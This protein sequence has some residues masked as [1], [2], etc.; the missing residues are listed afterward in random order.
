MTEMET[1][2]REKLWTRDFITVSV[3]NFLVFLIHLL[4]MVIIAFYAV[5]EF[6]ATTSTA[7]LV[8]SIFIVGALI[9][10]FATGHLIE[11]VGNKRVLIGG[12]IFFIATAVLY[13]SSAITLPLLI[14]I[15]LFHGIAHGIT[16][17]AT[18]TIVA[19]IIPGSKR[20]EG[21]GYYGMSIILASALGPF[22]GIILLQQVEFKTIFLVNLILAVIA[23][24]I[25]LVVKDPGSKFPEMTGAQEVK[26]IY[27][28]SFLE[29]K[30]IPISIVALVVGFSCSI[31][32]A[33]MSLYAQEIQLEKAASVYFVVSAVATLISR[34][35]AGRLFD[36][37]GANFVVYPCLF[38][39]AAG[40]FLFS[41]AYNGATLLLAGAIIGLSYGNFMSSAQ[42]IA[43][44][45]VQPHRFGLATATYYVFLDLGIATGPYLLGS[46]IPVT[47]YRGLYLMMAIVALAT[48]PLYHFL[49]GRKVS[50]G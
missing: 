50:T 48:V 33:F 31:V 15:R 43:I 39:Y 28:A 3:I 6:H 29:P 26:R 25:S 44:K 40:M 30:S 42:T 18:G 38:I 12:A 1:M 19:K 13:Y 49:C 45:V 20:G 47:G 24:S 36:L 14:I 41:Q 27:I 16:S 10:R 32:M 21:I 37:R 2:D 8:A 5:D 46:L 9:G 4:L 22:V 34:P 7:G 23:F 11:D 17:T 35:F